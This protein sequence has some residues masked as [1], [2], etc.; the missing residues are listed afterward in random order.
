MAEALAEERNLLRS[1]IDSVPDHIYVKDT[2]HR[3]VLANLAA[4]RFLG[5][6]TEELVGKT[7]QDLFPADAASSFRWEEEQVMRWGQSSINREER[8]TAPDGRQRWNL[9]TKVPLRDKQLRIVGLVGINRDISERKRATGE[10]Q[11]TNTIL[12]GRERELLA[13][14]DELKRSH[15]KLEAMQL[16]LLQVEK[17]ES[18]GRLAAG[19]AH[20]VKN[21]LA[22]ISTGIDY[23]TQDGA[24]EGPDALARVLGSMGRAVRRA[25]TVIRGLLD[26]SAPAPLL[27]EPCDLNGVIR[28]AL[29][30]VDHELRRCH[31][32]LHVDLAESLPQVSIDANK[33]EQV[34]LNLFINSIHAMPTGGSLTVRTRAEQLAALGHNISDHRAER[35]RAG[36]LVVITEVD[37]SG[38]GIPE[39]KLPK[40]F[41][42]FFT[43]K[44]TGKGTGL[45]LS[46]AKT[47][48]DLHGGMLQLTNRAEGGVRA[49]LVLKATGDFN[50][51]THDLP[52]ENASLDRGRRAGLHAHDGHGAAADRAV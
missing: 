33:V 11:R 47:I 51:D 6:T 46:V 45:G 3:F 36:D 9:T 22:I 26:F 44:P 16:Q 42:P 31:V 14:V 12:E 13:V 34:F 10:L 20:E 35:F 29:M 28:Q 37:D 49:S 7:D 27:A 41:D 30:L 25:D 38:H 40:V 19:I 50:H 5:M 21:P 8:I 23:L 48:V 15:E 4:Q 52:D 24:G 39:D 2:R 18:V 43:T 1:L 17:M 32:S